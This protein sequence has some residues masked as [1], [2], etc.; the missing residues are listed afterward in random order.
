MSGKEDAKLLEEPLVPA[1][2]LAKRIGCDGSTVRERRRYLQ[3]GVG[4][5]AK[6]N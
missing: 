5:Y 1:S 4:K 2:T 3:S 6:S